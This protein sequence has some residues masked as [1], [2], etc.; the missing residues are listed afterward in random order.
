MPF[1]ISVSLTFPKK[2]GIDYSPPVVWLRKT[3]GLPRTTEC[4]FDSLSI[5][6]SGI[7]FVHTYPLS[8]FEVLE[9]IVDSPETNCQMLTVSFY[10]YLS[11]V[12]INI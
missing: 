7:G 3:T 2:A 11:M 1:Y 12:G 9:R 8:R 5:V 4:S 6:L 10:I